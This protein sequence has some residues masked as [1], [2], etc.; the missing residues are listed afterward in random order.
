MNSSLNNFDKKIAIWLFICCFFVV[1]MVTIGGV[2]RLTDSGLSMTDWKPV[3]GWLPP[4][5]EQAW[6]EEFSKYRTSPEY[7]KINYQMDL[8]G[9][10]SIFWLEY[11]HRLAGRITGIIFLLPL[12]YFAYRKSLNRNLL[13]KLSA[14]L[15]LGGTQGVIGWFMVSSGLKDHPHVSQ[16]WL[17]FHLTTAFIIFAL[18]YLLGLSLYNKNTLTQNTRQSSLHKFSIFITLTIFIQTILGAFVAGLNAGLV[19]NSFPLM[20]GQFVPNGLLTLEPWYMNFFD[21]IT[22]VQFQHRMFAYAVSIFIFIL[23]L[24]S[25]KEKLT[26]KLR[27]AINLLVLMVIIQF[28]LGVGTIILV[29]PIWLAS[30]HQVGALALLT[31]SLYINFHSKSNN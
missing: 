6:Q 30:I 17:A 20:D 2:T 9:F 27:K 15:A 26:P 22:T 4:I 14:I 5:T 3:T 16:Y 12:L 10:K 11:I 31:I 25:R 1:L 19:Y 29:V 7:K 8:A 21:N 18:I 23:W 13:G 28:I 24:K